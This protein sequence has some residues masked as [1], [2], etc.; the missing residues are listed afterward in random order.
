MY[1]YMYIYVYICLCIDIC[2][3]SYEG[4]SCLIIDVHQNIPEFLI[5]SLNS[6]DIVKDENNVDNDV[7]TSLQFYNFK[8]KTRL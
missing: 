2:R 7:M 4:G 1:I 8:D 5:P 3:L 6:T